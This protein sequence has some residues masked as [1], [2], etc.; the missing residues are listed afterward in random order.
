M[1]VSGRRFLDIL[2]G[3][4]S[5]TN[6]I[7]LSETIV[8]GPIGLSAMSQVESYTPYSTGPHITDHV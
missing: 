4:N 6:D 5:A 1:Q 3:E 8:I 7:G 2:D